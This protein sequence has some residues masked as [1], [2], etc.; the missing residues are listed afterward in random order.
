MKVKA[1]DTETN[2]SDRPGKPD[3]I[4]EGHVY[5]VVQIKS[6]F[7]NNRKMQMD[8]YRIYNDYG[9]LTNHSQYRFE[10][11]DDSKP[12]PL[13]KSFNRLTSDVRVENRELKEKNE[14][15][16]N[17]VEYYRKLLSVE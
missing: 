5:E 7:H 15:L 12:E 3:G 4:T 6:F 9:K 10:V 16:E 13:V 11:V 17:L 14:K 1:I 2:R 8:Q